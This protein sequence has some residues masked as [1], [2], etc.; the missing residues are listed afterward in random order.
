MENHGEGRK[1]YRHDEVKA[2]YDA[3]VV[4]QKAAK[5][6][7]DMAVNLARAEDEAAA[8]AHMNQGEGVVAEV[9][10]CADE[11][12]P[13]RPCLRSR[14]KGIRTQR[15]TCRTGDVMKVWQRLQADSGRRRRDDYLRGRRH[16]AH[17]DSADNVSWH[18]D[19]SR[20][21]SRG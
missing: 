4:Q 21:K 14:D 15:R 1:L 19:T 5:S 10:S 8:E 12:P 16:H 2:K 20:D 11:T 9:Q 18:V 3:A 13:C 6:Q 7:Y 17:N